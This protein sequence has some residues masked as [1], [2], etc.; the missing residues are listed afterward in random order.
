MQLGYTVRVLSTLPSFDLINYLPWMLMQPTRII[1]LPTCALR[2]E[3][4]WPSKTLYHPTRLHGITIQ[5]TQ[6]YRR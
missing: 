5:I 4:V 6:A 3:A 1:A 2:M